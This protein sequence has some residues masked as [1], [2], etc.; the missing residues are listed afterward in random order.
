ML[1][2]FHPL[3][4]IRQSFV[5][6]TALREG[7]Q[8]PL[9]K[10]FKVVSI[11][12]RILLSDAYG[13]KVSNTRTLKTWRNDFIFVY[14]SCFLH[15]SSAEVS[16]LST[17]KAYKLNKFLMNLSWFRKLV[18]YKGVVNIAITTG[19]NTIKDKLSHKES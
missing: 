5:I 1:A 17:Y 16:K 13:P 15:V 18:N 2:A 6:G 14:L 4:I 9:S 12:L 19:W 10:E 11:N 8:I 7:L 3:N